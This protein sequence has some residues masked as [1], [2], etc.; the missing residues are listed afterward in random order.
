MPDQ[1]YKDFLISYTKADR[2][3]AEWIAWELEAAGYTTI[4]Q[5]WDFGAGTNFVLEMNKAAL[6]CKQTV[7]VLSPDFLNA[8]FTQL[9]WA[10]ALRQDPT[11]EKGNLVPVRVKMCEPEGLL[12]P[13]VYIDLVGQDEATAKKTLLAEIKQERA[14]PTHKP[15]FPIAGKKAVM[16]KPNF[17]GTL[18]AIWNIPHLRNPNFTGREEVLNQLHNAME[19]SEHS[20]R[21]QAIHGLGGVGKTQLALEYAYRHTADYKTVWWIRAEEPITRASD[22]AALAA[23]LD[24][25]EKDDHD[26][27]VI[28]AAVKHWLSHNP[29]WLLIFDNAPDAESVKDCLPQGNGGSV[30]VTSRNPIWSG[31]A[32]PLK[33]PVMPEED[34]VSFLTKSTEQ[35]DQEAAE[36]LAKEVGYLPLALAQARAYIEVTGISIADYIKLFQE[37]KELLKLGKL[38]DYPDTVATTWEIAFD[39]IQNKSAASADLMRLIAFFAPD[40]I[41]RDLIQK[42]AKHLPKR[43]SET[44]KDPLTFNDA[45]SALMRYSFIEASPQGISIHRLVQAVMRNGLSDKE[46]K[47]WAAIAVRIVN[48]AFPFD[49]DDFR[50]WGHCEPLLSHA[51]AAAEHAERM[52]VEQ[53][54]ASQLLNKCG[55]YLYSRAQY[56]Q[57]EPLYKRALAIRENALGPDHPNVAISLNDLAVLYD[58]QGKFTEAEPLHKRALAIKEKALGPDHPNVATSLNNLAGLYYTQGKFHEAEPLYQRALAIDEKAYGPNHPEVAT[59][60]NNLA[61]LYKTQGKF[62]EAEPLY[63]GALAIWEK[64]LGPDHPNVATSLNNLAVLYDTQGKFHEAEP[65]YKRSLAIKEKALGPDHPNVATSLE[66]LAGLYRATKRDKEAETLERRAAR[67]RAIKR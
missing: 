46:T 28:V 54:A 12:G 49:N 37:R 51:Q 22:Y 10:A 23:K 9:E 66:N 5:A 53:N 21:T 50:N 64:T 19:T 29:D 40:D 2:T 13:I 67:I 16:E 30:I 63:K 18:P 24:L 4:L 8:P 20:A 56:A 58:T 35:A 17:P 39:K 55:V 31:V 61:M 57:A 26:Q 65:L 42:G 27:N 41:P 34:A 43:L 33:V 15:A 36:V 7:A 62:H 25:Q 44:V 59:D 3:W 52:G 32:S 38:N 1:N 6:T 48:D 60:L 14:K 47:K 11:G 45:V